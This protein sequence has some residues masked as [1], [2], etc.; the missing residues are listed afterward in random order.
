MRVPGQD[1]PLFQTE[2]LVLGRLGERAI[3]GVGQLLIAD[4]AVKG[5]AAIAENLAVDLRAELLGAEEHDIQVPATRGDVDE[6]VAQ[7]PLP[8]R[9]RVFVQLVDEDDDRLH[10][11]LLLLGHFPDLLDHLRHED[12]LHIRVAIRDVDDPQLLVDERTVDGR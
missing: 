9:W 4:P 10:A 1:R 8:A 11:E 12:L 5:G 2:Q 3:G 7:A 6:G